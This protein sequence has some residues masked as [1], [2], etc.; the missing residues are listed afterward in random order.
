MEN[1]LNRLVGDNFLKLFYHDIKDHDLGGGN[2]LNLFTLRIDS[3]RLTYES[4]VDEL[5][6]S[7]ISFALSRKEID[8]YKGTLGGKRYNLA[9]EKL[10]KFSS[11][12]GELGEILLYCFLES[13]L[14]APKLLSKLELKTAK[15]NY[16]NGADGV[17][18]LQVDEK[19]YQIVFGESKLEAELTNCIYSAF[20]SVIDFLDE[21]KGKTSFELSLVNS[22]LLKEAVTDDAYEAIK[23]IIIPSASEDETNID[24]AFGLFLGFDL[25]ITDEQMR[26]PN[27]EFRETVRQQIKDMTES[28]ISSISFQLKKAE[29]AGYSFYIYACPFTDLDMQRKALIEKLTNG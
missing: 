21:A 6:E 15:N 19:N 23:N 7:L 4:L 28:C 12:D 11:N 20:G 16:V 14:K 26:L 1:H 8:K 3:N 10:R 29:L 5:Y 22:N 17:H 24:K 25:P 13:H 2:G 27:A 18:L 9:K